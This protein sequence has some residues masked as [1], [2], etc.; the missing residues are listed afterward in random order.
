ML[1]LVE[2]GCKVSKAT[3]DAIEYGMQLDYRLRCP[4]F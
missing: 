4:D 3:S 2:L 1:S